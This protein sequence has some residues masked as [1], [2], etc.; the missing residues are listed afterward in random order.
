MSIQRYE[1]R[2]GENICGR[3]T[4]EEWY[5]T[6][7]VQVD[8]SDASVTP[9]TP[10]TLTLPTGLPLANS[11]SASTMAPSPRPVSVSGIPRAVGSRCHSSSFL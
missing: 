4:Y 11:P 8:Q 10:S 3:C 6:V 9:A 2:D 1:C 5:T 7:E